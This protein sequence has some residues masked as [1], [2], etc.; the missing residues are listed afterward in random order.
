MLLAWNEF[1]FALILTFTESSK[2]LPVVIAGM[3]YE[4]GTFFGQMGATGALAML[5]VLALGIFVQKYL[6][7]GLTA[8]ALK[9]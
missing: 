8:G 5:P 6:L 9:G 4:R 7:Q 2:T 3:T 1:Q